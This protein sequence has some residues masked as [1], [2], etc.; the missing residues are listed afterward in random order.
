MS[1]TTEKDN[2]AD[3]PNDLTRLFVHTPRPVSD[4]VMF[5]SYK[6]QGICPSTFPDEDYRKAYIKYLEAH[7]DA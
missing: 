4:D 6:D 3:D 7:N 2:T 5:E 1:N